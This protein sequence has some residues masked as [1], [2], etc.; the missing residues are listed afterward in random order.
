MTVPLRQ[1]LATPFSAPINSLDGLHV[2]NRHE[3]CVDRRRCVLDQRQGD[4]G[5]PVAPREV[6]ALLPL[7]SGSPSLPSVTRLLATYK[8]Y[9]THEVASRHIPEPAD[10]FLSLAPWAILFDKLRDHGPSPP[11]PTDDDILGNDILAMYSY[12]TMRHDHRAEAFSRTWS[13]SAEALYL[14][15]CIMAEAEEWAFGR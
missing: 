1:G 6:L 15:Q 12:L 3:R 13:G 7:L 9:R 8:R 14:S 5:H 11:W 4:R 10:S 2:A